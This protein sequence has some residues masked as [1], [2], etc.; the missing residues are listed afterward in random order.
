MATTLAD[1]SKFG[2]AQ[3]QSN[4]TSSLSLT[5][6]QSCNIQQQKRNLAMERKRR[7]TFANLS[8]IHQYH[9]NVEKRRSRSYN[10]YK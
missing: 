4:S 3:G 7:K 5:P 9:N 10:R 6:E 8:R 2:I 1:F